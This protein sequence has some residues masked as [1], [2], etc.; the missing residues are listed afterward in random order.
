MSERWEK[1]GRRSGPKIER[2]RASA[3]RP[4]SPS[5]RRRHHPCCGRDSG[6]DH[7]PGNDGR[8]VLLVNPALD[9]GLA[10]VVFTVAAGADAIVNG[11]RDDVVAA[12][13]EFA[14]G[15]LDAA[16]VTVS[17]EAADRALTSMRDGGR[18]ACPHGAMPDPTVRPGVELIRYNGARSLDATDKL[19]RL[20]D[21]GPFDVHVARTFPFDRVVDAHRA[22]A[23]HYVGK[24]ALRV[25]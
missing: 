23:T 10:I 17:G 7:S 8:R 5:R 14:A 18:V 16:L 2:S 12:A 19:N 11:R 6:D 3:G 24:L 9:V 13:R 4:F 21:S 20:I 15:G 22:L 1:L 25:S